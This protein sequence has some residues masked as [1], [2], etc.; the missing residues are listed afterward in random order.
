MYYYNYYCNYYYY[1]VCV[2]ER[3]RERDCCT[4]ENSAQVATALCF[5]PKRHREKVYTSYAHE[6]R[7]FSCLVFCAS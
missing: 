4:R 5:F 2:R 6:K 3:E 7:L 1:C